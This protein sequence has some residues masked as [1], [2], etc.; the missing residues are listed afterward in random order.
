MD[1]HSTAFTAAA[2]GASAVLAMVIVRRL[3]RHQGSRAAWAVQAVVLAD[4]DA[5]GLDKRVLCQVFAE[6]H[7]GA[8]ELPSPRDARLVRRLV[9][10]AG[11][12]SAWHAGGACSRKASG[13]VCGSPCHALRIPFSVRRLAPSA[14]NPGSLSRSGP[15]P[16][17]AA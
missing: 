1:W 9:Q 6:L 14:S 7:R 3:G 8:A 2:A 11:R 5:P 10:S 15:A 17:R 16:R 13:W 4:G 12:D